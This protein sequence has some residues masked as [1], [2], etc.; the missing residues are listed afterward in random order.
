MAIARSFGNK[1]RQT[2]ACRRV[3]RNNRDTMIEDMSDRLNA[4]PLLKAHGTSSAYL[5]VAT[6]AV[7][8]GNVYAHHAIEN[9]PSKG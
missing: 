5:M 8:I 4:R 7:V 6:E 3:H 1:D 2:N 9:L